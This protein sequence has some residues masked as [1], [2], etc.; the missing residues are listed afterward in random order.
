MNAP[1]RRCVCLF[2]PV[3]FFTWLWIAK[4]L[5]LNKSFSIKSRAGHQ[6]CP[7]HNQVRTRPQSFF[8]G[9]RLD[10]IFSSLSLNP[11]L[12]LTIAL[13][14]HFDKWAQTYNKE[15]EKKEG[16]EEGGEWE[17][18]KVPIMW[19]KRWSETPWLVHEMLSESFGPLRSQT[20]N[21]ELILHNKSELL[22]NWT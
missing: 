22:Q 18:V 5:F 9:P 16:M 11:G 19:T 14:H 6:P 1:K 21:H 8:I 13:E 17:T 2:A 10:V 15:T 20:R 4:V 12:P 3:G 7:G